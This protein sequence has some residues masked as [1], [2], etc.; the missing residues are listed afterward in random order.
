MKRN[1]CWTALASAVA[2]CTCGA[3]APTVAAQSASGDV[4]AATGAD[5]SDAN[6]PDTSADSAAASDPAAAAG[7]N[8]A[9]AAANATADS[10]TPPQPSSSNAGADPNAS[11]QQGADSGN[12]GGS[13][14][15]DASGQSGQD[16]LQDQATDSLGG[17]A[18]PPAGA[19]PSGSLNA[20][21]NASAQAG[22]AHSTDSNAASQ[23]LHAALSL[24]QR[25]AR[26]LA[27]NSVA[28]QS[29]FYDSGLRP[30]DVIVS[31]AGRPLR[32]R[33]DFVRWVQYQPGQR[34]PVVVLRDGR[35]ETIYITYRDDRP[36]AIE[37]RAGYA[38]QSSGAY[39][40]VTFDPR[41]QYGAVVSDVA[42]GSPAE[43]AGID[44]GDA[45]VA[46][47]D[48]QVS[49]YQDVIR[50][51][52]AQHPGAQ[53]NLVVAHRVEL[54]A[55]PGQM[56]GS[57]YQQPA[58]VESSVVQRPQTATRPAA[59]QPQQQPEA[60]GQAND[61]TPQQPAVPGDNRIARPGDAD[62]DGRIL[63]GDGRINRR[64]AARGIG[65]ERR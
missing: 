3:Y 53:I 60:Y 31:Y 15:P 43:L 52:G 40:G 5:S 37:H 13:A 65:A 38:P 25:T 46:I 26:G 2:L 42:P 63:D 48:Q 59:P 18:N 64:E 61:F 7:A 24:G 45:I 51:V 23:D 47:N 58:A 41:G 9:G 34:V 16:Q 32:S 56:Q 62:R 57:T 21:L 39:L 6:T 28:P 11:S 8:T 44:A 27:I 49:N 19:N 54:S 30:G 29:V 50:I 33:E 20:D 22:A 1:F 12:L 4:T 55:R 36:G 35:E 17:A 10:Q 14:G